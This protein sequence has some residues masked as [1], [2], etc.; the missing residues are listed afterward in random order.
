M[1]DLDATKIYSSMMY[2]VAWICTIIAVVVTC[3]EKYSPF[4]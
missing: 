1:N 2:N 3:G 4:M